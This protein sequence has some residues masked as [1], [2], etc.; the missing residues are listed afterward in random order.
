MRLR[1]SCEIRNFVWE[2]W[3]VS[4]VSEQGLRRNGLG[5]LKLLV[6]APSRMWR[7]PLF[8][9]S[10]HILPYGLQRDGEF[11]PSSLSH[12]CHSPMPRESLANSITWLPDDAFPRQ[13]L[14]TL[15]FTTCCT[16]R[17]RPSFRWGW[18]AWC[19]RYW[20]AG[21]CLVQYVAMAWTRPA[22]PNLEVTEWARHKPE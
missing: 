13:Q 17:I 7:H 16:C 6:C 5:W 18:C 21:F 1:V 20:F 3:S 15:P 4:V 12:P 10:F 2:I 11:V 14:S 8:H 22:Q 9:T 19:T